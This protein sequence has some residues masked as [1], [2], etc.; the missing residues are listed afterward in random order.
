MRSLLGHFYNKIRGSQEDIASEGLTYILNESTNA[1]KT[2]SDLIK[3]ETGLNFNDL[4]YYTQNAG[5]KLK[6]PDISA[7]NEK[8]KE[9]L[10]IEAKF[11]ASLTSNQPNEYLNRLGDNTVLIFIVPSLRIK[12]IFEEVL[13]RVKNLCDEP[14]IEIETNRIRLKSNNKFILVNSWKEILI[15]IKTELDNDNDQR[16][17][18]DINQL[19]GLC[20]T[21]DNDS[22]QPIIDED[23]SPSIPKK[24][25]SY[26]EIVDKV[27]DELK[28]RNIELSTKGLVKTPQRYGYH[29]Y[30]KINNYAFSMSLKLNL[31]AEY[32]DTPFWLLI[33][34]DS[35]PK[36]SIPKDLAASCKI[37]SKTLNKTLVETSAELCISLN[38]KVNDTEDVLVNDLAN[39]VELICEKLN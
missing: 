32:S 23:L 21:I 20:E 25:N 38:P 18:S 34:K 6:R 7:I 8:G 11:W 33:W 13:T 10:L 17:L 37:L 39:Q 16:L 24:I 15:P 4:A 5:E 35:K 26:Y 1:R 30:F 19:I 29:R 9:V 28:S 36:W 22:F 2:I 3:S 27:V 12:P 14:D 31:W